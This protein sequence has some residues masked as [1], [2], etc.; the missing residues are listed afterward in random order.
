MIRVIALGPGDPDSVP[1]VALDAIRILS[2]TVFSPPL[3]P[4]IEGLI[5]VVAAPLPRCPPSAP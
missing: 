5:G 3:D 2:G 4:A 1:S